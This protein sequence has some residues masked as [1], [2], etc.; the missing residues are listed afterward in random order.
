MVIRTGP[1]QP[2]GYVPPDPGK[3]GGNT[4]KSGDFATSSFAKA[5]AAPNT[6]P[7]ISLRGETRSLRSPNQGGASLERIGSGNDQP[8][9]SK[10]RQ[11]QKSPR[12]P[13]R[14]GINSAA[15]KGA[16]SRLPKL[17][18]LFTGAKP[19]VLDTK[20]EAMRTGGAKVKL[21]KLKPS[22]ETK[23]MASKVAYAA[24]SGLVAAGGLIL[25]VARDVGVGII[26]GIFDGA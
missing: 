19:K 25:I 21:E 9:R 3:V 7:R 10:A 17:G 15:Q 12:T 1:N 11:S 8:K 5:E 6:L 16:G 23:K 14:P 18:G 22:D 24:M 4:A 26:E 2:T 13:A 20:G